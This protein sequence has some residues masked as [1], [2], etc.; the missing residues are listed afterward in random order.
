MG[1]IG[2][3]LRRCAGVLCFGQMDLLT[4]VVVAASLVWCELWVVGAWRDDESYE[5]SGGVFP[6]FVVEVR[7]LLSTG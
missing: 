7:V 5:E 1:R 6:G 4:L 3:W 2:C